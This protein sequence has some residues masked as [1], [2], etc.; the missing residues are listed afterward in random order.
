MNPIPY[1]TFYYQRKEE[2][3]LFRC[4]D[5]KVHDRAI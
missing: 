5:R 4:N 1:A 3:P 2:S